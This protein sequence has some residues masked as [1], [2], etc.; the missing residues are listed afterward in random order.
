MNKKLGY[1]STVIWGL[2]LVLTLGSVVMANNIRRE[3]NLEMYVSYQII[4]GKMIFDFELINQSGHPIQIYHSSGQQ[5]EVT[6]FDQD[7]SEVYRFSD[8]KAF[9]MALIYRDLTAG[10]SLSWRDSWNLADKSGERIKSGEY[11]VEIEVLAWSVDGNS[12]AKRERLV[13]EFSFTISHLDRIHVGNDE[14]LFHD[15]SLV[16]LY[17]IDD[18]GLTEIF[19]LDFGRTIEPVAQQL[20][21][22]WSV[23]DAETI[24]QYV[25]PKQGVRFTPYTYV[26]LEQDQVLDSEAMKKFFEDEQS[27]LWGYYDGKGNDIYLTPNE[28]YAEFVY[29][30]DFINAEEVGYNRVLSSGNMLENQFEVYQD[31][32]VVEYYFSGFNPD[33]YGMDWRSLRLVFEEY[34]GSWYLVGIIHNQWTV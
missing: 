33:Y 26:N 3:K 15:E 12:D 10:E 24:A 2:V 17:Q 18:Q 8:D 28:Y 16:A 7:G 19:K 27:Y 34:H 1:I 23:K 29:S 5:F 25:H 30:H 31:P 9:T 11:S 20:I 14:M 4:D 21:R 6:V 22:A 13:S 32:I